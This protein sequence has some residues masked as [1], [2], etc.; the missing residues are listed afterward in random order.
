MSFLIDSFK[1]TDLQITNIASLDKR[2][3]IDLFENF[4]TKKVLKSSNRKP[5][6]LYQGDITDEN[7]NGLINFMVMMDMDFK[8]LK[9]LHG[10][11]KS[12]V[13]V[14]FEDKISVKLEVKSKEQLN[15]LD[16]VYEYKKMMKNISFNFSQMHSSF[17]F[18]VKNKRKSD[19]I[20]YN[21]LNYIRT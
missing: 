13:I 21:K 3:V 7:L 5:L 20:L 1:F 19:K 4:F 11:D 15:N 6:Y 18:K 14:N 10:I 17:T 12:I 2:G 16:K 8:N 9:L